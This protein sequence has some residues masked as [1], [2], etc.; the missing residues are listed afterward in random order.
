[1]A[2]ELDK[3]LLQYHVEMKD[4]ML[5]L[6]QWNQ[7]VEKVAKDS[8]TASGKI[9]DFAAD[10]TEEI[11]KLIPGIDK[12]SA[13]IKMLGV[14]FGVAAVA[15]GVLAVGVKSVMDMR[16]Q[17]NQQRK[18]GMD[19]GVSALRLEE[20]QRK[21]VKASGGNIT[22]EQTAEELKKLSQFS[23]AVYRDPTRIG[24]EARTARVLG[25]DM[26]APG[27]HKSVN[28]LM[29]QLGE[30][31]SKMTDAQVQAQA[32]TLGMN[33]DFALG[34]KKQGAQVGEI[35]ELTPYEISGRK[36]AQTDL[37]AFNA[38][39]ARLSDNFKKDANVLGEQLLPD[40]LKF[41]NAM[42]DLSEKLP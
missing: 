38:A 2:D 39:F 12:A 22:R 25:I 18:E 20:Y 37:E 35:T 15:V 33:Q 8:K 13:A 42:A 17:Y 23:S 32:K 34:L 40:F 6:E 16:N 1:M 11:G 26:G 36:A 14:E 3:F 7:K 9:K 27:Q 19:I 28:D 10:A 31:F 4:A 41:V 21:F 29:Q 5:R 30:K 24:T